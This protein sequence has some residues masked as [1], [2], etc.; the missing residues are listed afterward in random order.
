[1]AHHL[2]DS[3]AQ[4]VVSYGPLIPCVQKAMQINKQNLPMLSI[5]PQVDGTPRI[6]EILE[7]PNMGFA[8]PVEVRNLLRFVTC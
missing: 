6:E 7:D 4:M 3:G 2:A 8:D 1:M 5:G